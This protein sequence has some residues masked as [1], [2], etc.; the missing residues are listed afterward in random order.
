MLNV[1]LEGN[2]EAQTA[3]TL[4]LKQ[5]GTFVCEALREADNPRT[6]GVVCPTQLYPFAQQ[7]VY[8]QLLLS[9][10]PPIRLEV[11]D[12]A[13]LAAQGQVTTGAAAQKLVR[14]KAATH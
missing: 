9:G 10:F 13:A 3:Y 2:K 4:R 14:Q 12:F 1:N 11:M 8:H 6:L 7:G 5:A